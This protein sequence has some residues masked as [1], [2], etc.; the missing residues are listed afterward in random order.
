MRLVLLSRLRHVLLPLVVLGLSGCSQLGLRG[1]DQE[2]VGVQPPQLGQCRML[3]PQD[4]TRPSNDTEP[5]G[6]VKRHTAE[7]FAVGRFPADVGPDG[8]DDP[9]L[10]SYVFDACERRFRDWVAGD[11]SQVMRAT[12]TWAWFRPSEEAWNAGARWWRCDVVGGGEQ[13]QKLITLPETT[14][15]ILRGM[16]GDKWTVCVDGA[17]IDDSVK[18]PCSQPHGWR[19]VGTIVVGEPGDPY[20]GDKLVEARTRDSCSEWVGAW[21]N[22]P[23]DYDYAFTW[24]HRDEWQAGNRRSI[25]WAKTSR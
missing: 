11:E 6:C 24:F 1:G 9:A 14:R 20:P 2:P 5:V 17:T 25:C 16:P 22:Y 4:I 23:V 18:V 12:I 15:G 10:G 13:S 3:T 21:L 8:I 7:T 19:A